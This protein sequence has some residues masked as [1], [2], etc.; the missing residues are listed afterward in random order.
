[1]SLH[2][3]IKTLTF[4]F[5]MSAQS[6]SM[7]MIVQSCNVQRKLSFNFFKVQRPVYRVDGGVHTIYSLGEWSYSLV[8]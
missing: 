8:F 1:M 6:T 3:L 4:H 5:Q 2:F 7:Y